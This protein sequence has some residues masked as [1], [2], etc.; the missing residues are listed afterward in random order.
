LVVQVPLLPG[1]TLVPRQTQLFPNWAQVF[2]PIWQEPPQTGLVVVVVGLVV[3]VVVVVEPGHSLVLLTLI[4]E[5]ELI[6]D[7]PPLILADLALILAADAVPRRALGGTG[8]PAQAELFLFGLGVDLAVAR[9]VFVLRLVLA[10]FALVAF[11]FVIL[12]IAVLPLTFALPM[13]FLFL[14]LASA[15]MGNPAEARAPARNP[16]TVSRRLDPLA[17]RTTSSS[18]FLSATGSR[19]ECLIS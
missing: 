8:A 3:V 5:G 18:N 6:P 7:A 19:N 14:F 4:A 10:V 1:I 2:V 11:A 17:S 15:R 9:R 12:T 13:P 16:R